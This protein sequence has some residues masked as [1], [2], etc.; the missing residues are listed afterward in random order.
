MHNCSLGVNAFRSSVQVAARQLSKPCAQFLRAAPLSSR[1]FTSWPSAQQQRQPQRG[2]HG[3]N[4]LSGPSVLRHIRPAYVPQWA[5]VRTLI[6]G[7]TVI[8]HYV[9]LPPNYKDEDGL[10]FARHDLETHEVIAIFGP[11]ISTAAANKLL[12]I[13][14]GR[15]VAGTLDDPA[16]RLNTM[17]YS[18]EHQ[19]IALQYLRSHVPVDEIVNA[20]LRAEDELAALENGGAGKAEETDSGPGQASKLKLYKEGDADPKTKKDSVYG[21]SALDAIRAHNEAKWQ[22]ELRRC[23]EEKKKREEEEKHG[24]AG[25]LQAR[26]QQQRQLSPKMQEYIAKAQSSL[27]EPPNMSKWQRLGPSAA[28]VLVV[29]GLCLAYAA[30]YRPPKRADRLWPD[31]PPAAA[32]V[33]V[34]ILANTLGWAL[35]KIPPIWGFLNR[36]FMVVAAT[37]RAAAMLGSLFSHQS[38]THLLQNMLLLWFLGVRFHDDVGRGT[39]LATYFASGTAGALGT[40]TMAVL[41]HRLDLATL[42]ASGA[43]YGIGAAYLWLHRFEPFRMFGLPPPPSEGFQG[44]S[45]LALMAAINIGGIFTAQRFKVDFTA[46]LVGIGVGIVAA[47]L[48]QRRKLAR[49]REKGVMETVSILS[50]KD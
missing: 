39:F 7:Q 6:L 43:I 12:R 37:P 40:L 2:G 27:K 14:H 25:P 20:G 41:K 34:L 15:R 45:I 32:T 21:E 49:Q 48:V 31:V 3:P 17:K 8:T 29:S 50:T 11:N 28:A 33:G 26:G 30:T 44:L 10:P 38:L 36:Y 18:K 1:C 5:G 13:L 46:H 42:G 23:E 35:W 19:R 16:L 9:D 47:H 24:K 22:A 4:A